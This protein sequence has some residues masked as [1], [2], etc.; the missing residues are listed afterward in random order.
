MPWLDAAITW[1]NGLWPEN[2]WLA[3]DFNVRALIAILLV[4]LVCGA[5]GSLVVGNRMA[6]FSDALAHCAF[7]GLALGLLL[8]LALSIDDDE[9]FEQWKTVIM[10]VFGIGVGLLI[11]YVREKTSLA[12]DTVI[13]VF[14]AGA[15]GLGGVFV[16]AGAGRR[17]FNLEQFI[18]GDP[19]LVTSSDLVIL[20]LMVLLTGAFL[21]WMYNSLVLASFNPSLARSRRV[22]LR[23]SNYLFIALLGIVINL[24]LHIVGALL[25]NALLIVPA[26]TAAILGRNMRQLFWTSIAITVGVGFLGLWLNWEILTLSRRLGRPFEIGIGGTIVVLAVLMFTLAMVLSPRFRQGRPALS[27]HPE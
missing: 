11:A 13:G 6:F 9:H 25:I 8:A 3:F 22:P 1:F 5:V 12:S 24:S 27:R 19:L 15:V 18:F 14:F 2:S 4:A 10:V 20:F 21:V 16:K 7:A 26:A 23:L 17:L